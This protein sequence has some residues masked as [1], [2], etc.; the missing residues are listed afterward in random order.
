MD[1]GQPAGENC[2]IHVIG[3]KLYNRRQGQPLGHNDAGDVIGQH[4]LHPG[5][6]TI[7][8][9]S[10]QIPHFR[11]AKNLDSVGG[12][13]FRIAG[14]SETGTIDMRRSDLVTQRIGLSNQRERH[15]LLFGVK[16]VSNG[17]FF[18]ISYP[19]WSKGGRGL[20]PE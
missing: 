16:E 3:Q 10:L 8:I 11:F 20:P 6:Q 4:F 2:H 12:K 1:S 17:D 14:K 13:D 15:V 19:L 5:K 9:Q 7:F 18:H